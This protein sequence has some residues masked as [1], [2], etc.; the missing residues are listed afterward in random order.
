MRVSSSDKLEVAV[1]LGMSE[2]LSAHGYS[3]TSA[4][5]TARGSHVE[6]SNGS[7]LVTVTAD[8]LEGELDVTVN[9]GLHV[10]SAEQLVDLPKA[11]HLRR[12]GRGVSTDVIGAQLTKV[13]AAL[14]E[15]APHLFTRP[16]R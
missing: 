9:D 8:W 10:V 5:G 13:A 2:R 1:E 3:V 4:D 15:Q 7:V 12:L 6:F 14:I 11:T 16:S